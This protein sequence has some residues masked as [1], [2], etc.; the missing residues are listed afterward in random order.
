MKTLFS[1]KLYLQGLRKIRTAGIAMAIVITVMNA[2]IPIQCITAGM[3]EPDRMTKVEAGMF[4]PFGFALMLFAPLLVYNMFSYMNERKSS[5]FFHALPQKRICIYISFMSAVATWIVSVLCLTSIVNTVLWA[6]ADGYVLSFGAVLLTLFGF[7]LLALVMAGFMALAM[8][9]TGTAVANFLVFVL[10]F[11]FIRACGM[12]FVYGFANVAPM[13]N[14]SYSVLKL[15]DIQFFLP[16]GLLVQILD[17]EAAVLRSG[18]FWVYWIAVAVVLFVLSAVAYCRRRSE[19]ATKSAPNRLM[20]NIYR[21]GVTFPFLMMGV[22]LFIDQKDFYLCVL[23]AFVA[24]LVWVIFELL[25]TRRVKNVIRSIPML[26]IPAVLSGGYAGSVY[27][28]RDIFYA[29]TPEREEIESVMLAYPSDTWGYSLYM[30]DVAYNVK[31]WESVILTTT[32]IKDAEILDSVYEAIGHTKEARDMTWTE[33]EQKGY[34]YSE[35]VTVKL[36]SGRKITYNLKTSHNLYAE[37]SSSPQIVSLLLSVFDGGVDTVYAQDVTSETAELVWEAFKKDFN[38][39]SEAQKMAYLRL[40]GNTSLTAFRLA[41]YGTYNG[42]RFEQDYM[43][44]SEYTPNAY[45]LYLDHVTNAEQA[46]SDLQSA[47]AE[48]EDMQA[49]EFT[50]SHMNITSYTQSSTFSVHTSDFKMIKEFLMSLELD[51]HLT[52]YANAKNVYRLILQLEMPVLSPTDE[53]TEGASQTA[54]G[55][56][57]EKDSYRWTEIDIYLTFSD[58]DIERYMQIVNYGVNPIS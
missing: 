20:Q 57:T 53:T 52:D 51:S 5:D 26:L 23:C 7:L 35:S 34:I 4:A 40:N 32:E 8:T 45:Q 36:K 38:A 42:V 12:F 24:F 1:G 31:G 10:F 16:V 48:M 49:D 55:K 9:L 28:A 27:L 19:S 15:F 54:R 21:V 43:L 44:H 39:L 29:S 22:F 17:G 56:Y 47:V 33:R 6:M 18:W 14:I 13:F 50:Y 30:D 2:W 58:A 11:L 41:V 25:T 46:L 3:R 37:F